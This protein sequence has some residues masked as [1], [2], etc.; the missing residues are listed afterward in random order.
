MKTSTLSVY[1]LAGMA[2]A[3]AAQLV[4]VE[5]QALLIIEDLKQEAG[6]HGGFYTR[7]QIAQHDWLYYTVI[8]KID[9][10]LKQMGERELMDLGEWLKTFPIDES[11]VT[12][13]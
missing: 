3:T 7:A 10:K 13:D 12:N 8:P 5:E 6:S 4:A 2:T 1:D 9:R 11:E